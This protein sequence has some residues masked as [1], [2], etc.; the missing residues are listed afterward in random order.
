MPDSL[1]A[2]CGDSRR[3]EIEQTRNTDKP[4]CIKAPPTRVW[5]LEV[6][7]ATLGPTRYY[8]TASLQQGRSLAAARFKGENRCRTHGEP[9]FPASLCWRP[10]AVS[11]TP[12]PRKA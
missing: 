5:R 11:R 7:V 2:P 9:E 8:C 10:Y 12:L 3:P 4:C 6:P 1:R